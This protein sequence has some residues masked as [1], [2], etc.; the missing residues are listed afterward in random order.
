MDSEDEIKRR[1][2]LTGAVAGV[3]AGA[4]LEPSLAQAA[5]TLPPGF[6]TQPLLGRCL[7]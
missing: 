5:A 6:D 2:L 1:Y 4:V 3:V 7:D